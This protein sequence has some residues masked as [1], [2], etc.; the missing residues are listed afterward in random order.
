MHTSTAVDAKNSLIVHYENMNVND[1]KALV[2]VAKEAKNVLRKKSIEVLADKGYHNGEQLH[3]CAQYNIV[4]YV[5]VPDT[6]HPLSSTVPTQ[7]YYGKKFKYDQENDCF[8]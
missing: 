8:I 6:P 3:T 2:S 1:R 4:T 7:E 5:A